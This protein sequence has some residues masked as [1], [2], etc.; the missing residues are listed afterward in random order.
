MKFPANVTRFA[1]ACKRW[2]NRNSHMP[3][4]TR[5]FPTDDG[6]WLVRVPM[7]KEFSKGFFFNGN[8]TVTVKNRLSDRGGTVMSLDAFC[9]AYGG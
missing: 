6:G 7:Q 8:N 1:H 5:L 3:E 4:A 9:I 2:A